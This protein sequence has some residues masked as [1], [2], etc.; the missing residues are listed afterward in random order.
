MDVLA[1]VKDRLSIFKNLYDVIRLVN[2]ATNKVINNNCEKLSNKSGF[3]YDIWKRSEKCE[4]CISKIAYKTDETAI[5]IE[6]SNGKVTLVTA[7]PVVINENKYVVEMIKDISNRGKVSN[8]DTSYEEAVEDFLNASKERTFKD[9]LTGV[10]NKSYIYKRLPED[11]NRGE[12]ENQPTTVIMIDLDYF[13]DVNDTYGHV[14][15][16]KVL[17]D[18]SSMV[19]EYVRSGSMDWIGR[20]GGEE[21]ILVLNNCDGDVAKSIAERIRKK[22]NSSIF[23]YGDIKIKITCSIG[24][25]SANG[26][27]IEMDEIIGRADK[28][29]YRA[30]ESGRNKIVI[31]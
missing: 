9:G 6:Y 5:K 30:K 12:R 11:L 15:G 7:A 18:F 28:N 16:D 21:F 19:K 29:L 2:P 4:N 26:M 27:H 14:I 22:I 24:V 25:Y 8:M 13:K 20:Y 31:S 23:Q 1:E 10:Y 17:K 3:C